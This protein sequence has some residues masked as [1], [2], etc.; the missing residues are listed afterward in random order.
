MTYTADDGGYHATV[1]YH[2]DIIHHS[3]PPSPGKPHFPNHHLLH[4]PALIA[5]PILNEVEPHYKAPYVPT[6]HPPKLPV[7]AAPLLP[8]LFVP[9]KTVD[10]KKPSIKL[11]DSAVPAAVLPSP[12]PTPPT[13]KY[14]YSPTPTPLPYHAPEPFHQNPLVHAPIVKP[15]FYK[16]K[17][18]FINKP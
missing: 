16:G 14:R 5:D 15:S 2:G 6:P 7:T 12:P 8:K 9:E 3:P 1:E 4:G 11:E 18:V 17:L 13:P 10:L